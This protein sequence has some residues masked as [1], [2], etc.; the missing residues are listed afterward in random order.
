MHTPVSG[1]WHSHLRPPAY[2]INLSKHKYVLTASLA[3]TFIFFF[4]AINSQCKVYTERTM[5][6]LNQS[7]N[8]MFTIFLFVKQKT[9]DIWSFQM[10]NYLKLSKTYRTYKKFQIT[11]HPMDD[12]RGA[13]LNSGRIDL[14]ISVFFFYTIIFFFRNFSKYLFPL[15]SEPLWCF[16]W[17]LIAERTRASTTT[18]DR[19]I[20]KLAF[21]R[22]IIFHLISLSP[23]SSFT[24]GPDWLPD[25][26]GS[27]SLAEPVLYARSCAFHSPWCRNVVQ[28]SS[29]RYRSPTA[30]ASEAQSASADLFEIF[31]FFAHFF[32]LFLCFIVRLLKWS[33]SRRKRIR[34]FA[35]SYKILYSWFSR[36]KPCD[37]R[38]KRSRAHLVTYQYH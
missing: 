14:D 23:V 33:Y 19:S 13:I 4:F 12:S 25:S 9:P 29:P 5:K 27:S 34:F 11:L 3:L 8:K 26:P 22:S 28:S 38:S 32:L 30:F 7:C 20:S 10:T 16:S 15:P 17:F 35:S 36:D 21:R 24:S 1:Y 31:M 18:W 37:T 6:G 2:A